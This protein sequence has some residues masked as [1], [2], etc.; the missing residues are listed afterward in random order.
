ME[1]LSQ[2]AHAVLPCCEAI[3]LPAFGKLNA[4]ASFVKRSPSLFT[5]RLNGARTCSK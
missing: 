1:L 2:I 5:Q 4:L 3:A